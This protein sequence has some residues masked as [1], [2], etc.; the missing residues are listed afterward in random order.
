M[1]IL[2]AHRDEGFELVIAYRTGRDESFFHRAAVPRIFY[3]LIRRLSFPNMP[4]G[5]FDFLGFSRRAAC[6]A[7]E[8]G[9]E[10]VLPGGISLDRLRAEVLALSSRRTS[11]GEGRSRWT[12]RKKLTFFIDGVVSYSDAPLRW[13]SLTGIVCA[14][15][16]I[17][18]AAVIFVARLSGDFPFYGW[19]R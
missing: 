2:R 15:L 3:S 11:P 9:S 17:L 6:L 4:E 5:G 12:F 18:Y 7:T 8:P 16:G 14:L 13:M 10:S 1:E 19:A